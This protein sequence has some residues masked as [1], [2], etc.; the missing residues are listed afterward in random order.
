M[1]V[2]NNLK[3]T[4]GLH[5]TKNNNSEILETAHQTVGTVVK[6]GTKAITAKDQ[7]PIL[8]IGEENTE[9]GAT[10]QKRVSRGIVIP[11]TTVMTGTDLSNT[12]TTQVVATTVNQQLAG[13]VIGTVTLEITI[14][15][16]TEKVQA[17]KGLIRLKICQKIVKGITPH[18]VTIIGSGEA[19]TK[20]STGA[21]HLSTGIDPTNSGKDSKATMIVVL[22]LEG[23]TVRLSSVVG[24][25]PVTRWMTRTK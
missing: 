1:V 15:S 20:I 3:A 18:T 12:T 13:Q 4:A 6:T 7:G 16:L 14:V 2:D 22:A 17:T 24:L 23:T 21:V 11:T 10:H 19:E 8:I 25:A 5:Q 9:K